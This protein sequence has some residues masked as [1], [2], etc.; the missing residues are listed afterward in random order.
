MRQSLDVLELYK[1]K[2]DT[3]MIFEV[4]FKTE[5]KGKCFYSSFETGAT[6]AVDALV[7]GYD[8]FKHCYGEGYK[9]TLDRLEVKG[10]VD[11]KVKDMEK[12]RLD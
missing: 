11:S 3:Q 4:T 1:Y 2:F 10:S 9:A 5:G 8:K 6:N 12:W 7:K